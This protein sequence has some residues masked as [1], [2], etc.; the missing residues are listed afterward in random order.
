[1][2][3][4]FFLLPALLLAPPATAQDPD[5][6]EI[7]QQIAAPDPAADPSPEQVH[8]LTE[9][10]AT[11][12]LDAT[13]CADL[14]QRVEAYEEPP[15]PE[16]AFWQGRAHPRNIW[17][18]TWIS[19]PQPSPSGQQVA[20][21]RR[22]GDWDTAQRHREV[23]VVAADG[24]LDRPWSTGLFN[25]THPRWSPDGQWLAFLTDRGKDGE[26]VWILSTGGGEAR[27][28]T[29]IAG[30]LSRFEWAP[31][32]GGLFV[33][34]PRDKTNTELR[35]EQ[36]GR[37]GYLY[38]HQGRNERLGF[39]ALGQEPV[40]D[41][42]WI[43]D[44]ARHVVDYA[45]CPD[46]Q[47]LA[48]V[49]A[50]EPDLY[51]TMFSSRVEVL[52]LQGHFLWGWEGEPL[53]GHSVSQLGWSP[54]GRRLAFST[55]DGTL[56][57]LNLLLVVDL[58]TS[59]EWRLTDPAST[60]LRQFTWADNDTLLYT[61]L[62][63]PVS[64]VWRVDRRGEAHT[65]LTDEGAEASTV[66]ASGRSMVV[67]VSRR[68]DPGNLWLGDWKKPRSLRRLTDANPDMLAR[69]PYREIQRVS[70]A[71]SDGTQVEGILALPVAGRAP[72]PLL[73]WPH[74]GPD[75]LATLG[76]RRWSAFFTANGY[77]V[78]EPNFR[79]S[80]G[81]GRDFYEANRGKLGQVD[82][83]DCLS[84]V[85]FLVQQG[86]AD[87][88]RLVV[89]G[90]SYGGTLAGHIVGH[91]QRFK[92]AVAVAGVSDAVSNYGQSDV[93]YGLAAQWEFMGNPVEQPENFLRSSAIF[94]V[95]GATTPTLVM[96]GEDDQRVRVEQGM[97]LYRA[98]LAVG[99]PTEMVI[100]P[101]E[102]HGISGEPAQMED[103]LRR[104]LQ[105]YA[106]YLPQE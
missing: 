58:D 47:R 76:F 10:G 3:H 70:W 95:A 6:T 34:A 15:P 7:T 40:T 90:I 45:V 89:G 1:M 23:W 93:N 24:S 86:L 62:E 38:D 91:S 35:D 78:F 64:E 55:Y 103:H 52:D 99:A 65:R 8:C 98:L 39:V 14:C 67:R 44:G 80:V 50:P 5:Y 59:Q 94:D 74:G 82:L 75:W 96:H 104:W 48:L 17:E 43:T 88:D 63:G 21:V 11:R 36:A 22:V 100:Y 57:L 31:D 81:Y 25:D 61:A 16:Q 73:L 97:E 30:G 51:D 68:D 69:L 106:R 92:A 83:D 46:G 87:P 19:D 26:Q 33:T 60:N 4:A 18:Y 41:V 56:S 42:G 20:Y 84:G 27:P 54:D 2:R 72:Y 105:W 102:G 71:A 32:G 66:M 12:G 77:A 9:C 28:V 37:S 79:G 29:E 49:T 13:V 53:R 85:D 101:G